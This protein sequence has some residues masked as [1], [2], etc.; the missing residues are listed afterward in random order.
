[1][2]EFD[3]PVQVV[4]QQINGNAA[5]GNSK[6]SEIEFRGT[7]GTLFVNNANW[8]VVPEAIG[9]FPAGYVGGKGYGNP[10]DRDGARR[11]NRRPQ[12]EPKAVKTSGAYD[13][14]AHARNFLDCIKSRGKCNADIVIGHLSTSATLIGNIAHKTRSF[15]EWDAV[16]EK[17]TNN[18]KAN[19]FLHYQ[20]RAPYRLG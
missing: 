10:V 7:K 3:K 16:A 4:F 6:G 2:W 19:A 18:P 9:D 20:Y 14:M 13:T 11:A 8:E 12:I 17:F 1:M 5:P 15:L